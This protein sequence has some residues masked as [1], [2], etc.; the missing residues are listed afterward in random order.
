MFGLIPSSQIQDICIVKDI[1]VL[2]PSLSCWIRSLL[3]VVSMH[4]DMQRSHSKLEEDML[5]T[6]ALI[7]VLTVYLIPFC[8]GFMRGSNDGH[9]R[10]FGYGPISIATAGG[11]LAII[12]SRG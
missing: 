12:D 3:I 10:A 5:I 2:L 8:L 1:E 7:I 9:S 4:G 11:G 6:E